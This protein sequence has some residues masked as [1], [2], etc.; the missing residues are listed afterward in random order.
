MESHSLT[1]LYQGL[2]RKVTAKASKNWPDL[3]CFSGWNATSEFLVWVHDQCEG[4][5]QLVHFFL[6]SLKICPAKHLLFLFFRLTVRRSACWTV[7][8]RLLPGLRAGLLFGKV[9]CGPWMGLTS[10]ITSRSTGLFLPL[11]AHSAGDSA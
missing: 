7:Q 9:H 8:Q 1:F 10:R 11:P 4:D 5:H 3:S 6:Y 2:L